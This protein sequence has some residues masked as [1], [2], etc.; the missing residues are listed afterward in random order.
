MEKSG[1]LN[2]DAWQSDLER[3]RGDH[4]KLLHQVQQ[5]LAGQGEFNGG[6]DHQTCGFGKWLATVRVD[7]PVILGVQKEAAASHRQFHEAVKK[8]KDLMKRGQVSEAGAVVRQ[9]MMPAAENTFN[10]LRIVQEEIAR[11]QE[12]YRQMNEQAM[13]K[14]RQRQ[15]A[16]LGALAELRKANNDLADQLAAASLSE[17]NRAKLVS[18]V[19][20]VLSFGLALGV[21]LLLSLSITR[22][23]KRV[24]TGLSEAS[25]QVAAAATQVSGASQSLAQGASEQAASLEETSASL[26][27]L[28]SMT[29]QNADNANQANQLMAES[30]RVVEQAGQAMQALI[31]AMQEVS[32]ASENTGKIIKTIDEIAFQTNLLALNAAV[33]AARA[34]EAGAGFAVVADEVRSLAMRAAEAAKNTADLIEGTLAR[35]R[36]SSDL[37]TKTSGAFSQ[38]A[39][40]SGKMRDLVS[41]IAAASSEQAQGVEQINKAVNE[42]NSV[43]QQNAANAE[44]SASASEELTAQS[45]QMKDIVRE[46]AKLVGNRANGHRPPAAGT[47]ATLGV[48]FHPPAPPARGLE[49]SSGG[50][51]ALRA[52]RAK[53]EHLIPFDQD[54]FKEF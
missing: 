5:L 32:T 13:V 50:R 27:Q 24:I 47:S 8:I 2:P 49:K 52:G 54:D 15:V 9:E 20:M 44:E 34:G 28:A 14:A 35:V 4:Y 22:A 33:E 17:A 21:G 48:G 25:E 18:L 41:E 39:A 16:A 12:L 46:L 6:N 42:M 38:V 19:S 40:D 43:T 31:L 36:E 23:L 30:N 53:P 29:R 7:N 3:F 45:E 26:E 51:L 37:V 10:H 1:I 11:I